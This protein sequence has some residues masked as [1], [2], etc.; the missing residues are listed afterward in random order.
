MK[1]L[2]S[3]KSCLSPDAVK[4]APQGEVRSGETDFPIAFVENLMPER[5]ELGTSH[6]VF[7]KIS[8]GARVRLRV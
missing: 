2:L 3:S 6:A 1:S 8:S 7:F 4:G 5:H